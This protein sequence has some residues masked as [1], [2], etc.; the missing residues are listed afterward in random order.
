MRALRLVLLLSTLLVSTLA[1]AGN[2]S[3]PPDQPLAGVWSGTLG[4]TA[5]VACFD[6]SGEGTYYYLRLGF[7]LVLEPKAGQT[8]EWNEKAGDSVTGNWALDEARGN[9]VAGTWRTPDGKKQLP[10]ALKYAGPLGDGGCPAP[11]Y[12]AARINAA[13]RT[14]GAE[15][16]TFGHAWRPVSLGKNAVVKSVELTDPG[17]STALK[18]AVAAVTTEHLKSY[19]GCGS[20]PDRSFDSQD[21]IVAWTS[22]IFVLELHESYFCGGAYPDDVTGVHTFDV[23]TGKEVDT[24]KWFKTSPVD[25]AAKRYKAPMEECPTDDLNWVGHPTSSGMVYR[26]SLPHVAKGCEVDVLVPWPVLAGRLTP[27]GR[28]AMKEL[29][30]PPAQ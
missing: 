28:E 8:R 6:K 14:T 16:K 23:A 18:Q 24:D 5:I 20:G 25:L 10:V 12:D 26:P 27:Q 19:F 29:Q 2:A 9:A 21:S 13:A 22:T 11:A 17:A 15:T 30:G 4:K 1:L 3:S 7:D